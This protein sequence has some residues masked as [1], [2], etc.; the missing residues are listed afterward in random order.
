MWSKS[1]EDGNFSVIRQ[2]G[3]ALLGLGKANT[4]FVTT[5][6]P[7]TPRT[8]HLEELQRCL[9]DCTNSRKVKAQVMSLLDARKKELLETAKAPGRLPKLPAAG[10][11]LPTSAPIPRPG[12][13]STMH[14]TSRKP[15]PK[16][17]GASRSVPRPTPSTAPPRRPWRRQCRQSRRRSIRAAAQG[18]G[19][20]A[21]DGADPP[22]RRQRRRHPPPSSWR[23]S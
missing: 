3:A 19:E 18:V 17:T 9:P 13:S 16:T 2:L 1:F 15:R 5:M 10:G 8:G 22:D 4:Y 23:R 7:P 20:D 6:A 14:W 11:G 21:G 12:R